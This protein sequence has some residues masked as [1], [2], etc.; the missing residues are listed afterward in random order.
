M[1]GQ[2]VLSVSKRSV[3]SLSQS[4]PKPMHHAEPNRRRGAAFKGETGDGSDGARSSSSSLKSRSRGSAERGVGGQEGG[5]GGKD[6]VETGSLSELRDA[7]RAREDELLRLKR[8]VAAAASTSGRS[9]RLASSITG[10]DSLKDVPVAAAAAESSVGRLTDVSLGGRLDANVESR[11]ITY[12]VRSSL[13]ND[14]SRFTAAEDR[15]GRSVFNVDGGGDQRQPAEV[16]QSTADRETDPTQDSTALLVPAKR[17]GSATDANGGATSLSSEQRL[18]LL[19]PPPQA[20]PLSGR[21]AP[22][23]GSPLVASAYE[24]LRQ[25]RM[26]LE[27]RERE[28]GKTKEDAEK[29]VRLSVIFEYRMRYIFVALLFSRLLLRP[30]MN[31]KMFC[32][33]LYQVLGAGLLSVFACLTFSTCASSLFKV[34]Q[35]FKMKW[36][37]IRNKVISSFSALSLLPSTHC[38]ALPPHV[39]ATCIRCSYSSP[40]PPSPCARPRSR[41]IA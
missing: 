35:S 6:E 9:R 20:F 14:T 29:L 5:G 16:S 39:H 28:A 23:I 33:S 1:H 36:T 32:Q 4:W 13:S 41:T 3:D 17:P 12:S 2:A 7:L 10:G 27:E 25:M 11:P 22:S 8:D 15:E 31:E 18:L 34:L 37:E 30:R 38:A 26:V 21:H 40:P 24:G 19:P